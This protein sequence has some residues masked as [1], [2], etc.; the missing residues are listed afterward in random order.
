MARLVALLA[1]AQAP[2]P[3]QRRPTRPTQGSQQRRMDSKAKRGATKRL[4]GTPNP[5]S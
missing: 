3:P 4:R 1:E 2:P 5:E